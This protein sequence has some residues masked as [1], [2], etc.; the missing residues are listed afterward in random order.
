M[1]VLLAVAFAAMVAEGVAFGTMSVGGAD[2]YGYVTQS[3]HWLDGSIRDPQ[4]WARDLPWPASAFTFT[5]LGYSLSDD[6]SSIVSQYPPGLPLLMAGAHLLAGRCAVF[7]VAPL[8][9]GL[10]VVATYGLGRQLGSRGA[11]IAAMWLVATS[12]AVLFMTPAPM[13]DVPAAAMWTTALWLAVSST[14]LGRDRRSLW[15]GLVSGVAIL[16]RPNLIPAAAP[17]VIWYA[18]EAW[19]NVSDRRGG[20]TRGLLFCVGSGAGVVTA[21]VLNHAI[22]HWWL[23]TGYGSIEEAFGWGN[24]RANAANYFEWLVSTQT[25]L[26]VAGLAALALPL[27]WLWPEAKTRSVVVLLAAFCLVIWIQYCFYQVFDLWWYLRFLLPCWPAIMIGLAQVVW[28]IVRGRPRPLASAGVAIVAALGAFGIWTARD[29]AAFDGGLL[30]RRYASVGAMVRGLTDPTS[31]IFSMQHSGSIRYYGGRLT[32]NFVN[33]DRRYL[34]Q[35]VH[36]LADH[37]A[38]PYAALEEWEVPEFKR[39]FADENTAGRLEMTPLF[40]YDGTAHVLFYD[41]LQDNGPRAT[42]VIRETGLRPRCQPPAKD[43]VIGF[44]R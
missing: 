2:A 18:W 30:E 24:V 5:P 31:V 11:A 20:I 26:A 19:R 40:E 38:H 36:W 29:R 15:A 14:N 27:P 28:L 37:G 10:L 8:C 21:V 6:E 12:P 9:A 23:H 39:R 32:L 16:I 22:T 34:D 7:W 25:P 4:P 1:R 17:I 44:R 41:L 3:D 42:G 43:M 33:L 35:T 13:S